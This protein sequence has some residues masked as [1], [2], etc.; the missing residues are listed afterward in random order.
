MTAL[1]SKPESAVQKK[2]FGN[3]GIIICYQKKGK[4]SHLNSLFQKHWIINFGND[5]TFLRQIHLF[6]T[7]CQMNKLSLFT[8]ISKRYNFNKCFKVNFDLIK[9]TS[10]KFCLCQ[11]IRT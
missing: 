5:Q 3:R 7:M 9:M 1:L 4:A 8:C 2:M 11:L 10:K 6:R